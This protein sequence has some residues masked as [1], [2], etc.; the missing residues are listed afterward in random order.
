MAKPGI[1]SLLSPALSAISGGGG[2][3]ALLPLLS[4]AAAVISGKGDGMLAGLSP[5]LSTLLGGGEDGPAP[6]STPMSQGVM[7]FPSVPLGG[8]GIPGAISEAGAM[9]SSEGSPIEVMGDAWK[10]RKP[11]LLGALADAYLTYSGKPPAFQQN[12]DARS[13]AEAMEGFDEDPVRAIRR[14]AKMKGMQDE[15]WN[16]YNQHQDNSRADR[17]AGRQEDVASMKYMGRHGGMLNS[18][19]RSQNPQ[20]QYDKM[21]P[22]LQAYAQRYNLPQLPNAYDPDALNTYIM[23]NVDVDD[24]LRIEQ[25]GEYQDRRLQQMDRGLDIRQQGQQSLDGYRQE[26]LQDFDTAEEG[27]NRR[28]ATPPARAGGA[29]QGPIR[30]KT[31]I[32]PGEMSPD[33]KKVRVLV[34]GIPRIYKLSKDGKQFVRETE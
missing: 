19:Q 5:L 34:N 3:G 26:R 30:V 4:P 25:K 31:P 12:R 9:G 28:D 17:V 15:A 14:I 2:T 32:G 27:R 6:S 18:I 7:G 16:M 29:K 11:T 33:G 13:M 22:N 23:G 20:A 1:A 10:P 8:G 24:Q 21:L